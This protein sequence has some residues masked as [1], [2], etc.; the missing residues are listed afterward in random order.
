MSGEPSCGDASRGD[1]SDLAA[2]KVVRDDLRCAA[3]AMPVVD[4]EEALVRDTAQPIH[5]PMSILHRLIS[6]STT[7]QF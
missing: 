2:A 7:E 6:A 5:E 3:A 1:E 4:T